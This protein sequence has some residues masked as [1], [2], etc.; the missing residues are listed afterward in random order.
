MAFDI[1]GGAFADIALGYVGQSSPEDY[2]VPF[3]V[4]VLL[5]VAV[6]IALG[7]GEGERCHFSVGAVVRVSFKVTDFRVFA[8][9][10][11]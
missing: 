10:T 7:R 11:D 4:F 5:A 9:V 3:G 8:D 6:A 1:D 2:I